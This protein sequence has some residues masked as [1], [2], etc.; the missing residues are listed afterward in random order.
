MKMWHILHTMGK[1][2]VNE[3]ISYA[4]N[5]PH[6]PATAPDYVEIDIDNI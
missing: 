6:R 5:M 3:N 2:K 4:T 1:I